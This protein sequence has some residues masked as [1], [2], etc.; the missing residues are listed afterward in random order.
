MPRDGSDYGY[1]YV[2]TIPTQSDLRRD[3]IFD[4]LGPDPWLDPQWIN[5]PSAP[6][7]P[8]DIDTGDEFDLQPSPDSVAER[9]E[10][11]MQHEQAL[12][13]EDPVE[14]VQANQ[15][16]AREMELMAMLGENGGNGAGHEWID[17]TDDPEEIVGL[18]EDRF[19]ALLAASGGF[20][21][22]PEPRPAVNRRNSIG[23]ET[24]VSDASSVPAWAEELDEVI[25]NPDEEEDD[26]LVTSSDPPW[27]DWNNDDLDNQAPVPDIPPEMLQ[28]LPDWSTYDFSPPASTPVASFT[29]KSFLLPPPH[30][31]SIGARYHLSPTS[32]IPNTFLTSQCISHR[33]QQLN[34]TSLRPET[35][36][37]TL[38]SP[39]NSLFVDLVASL[40]CSNVDYDFAHEENTLLAKWEDLLRQTI[41]IHITAWDMRLPVSP[42]SSVS[43]LQRRIGKA[44][45]FLHYW[46]EVFHYLA[47]VVRNSRSSVKERVKLIP[48]DRDTSNL[49]ELGL[50][51]DMARWRVGRVESVLAGM[52]QGFFQAFAGERRKCRGWLRDRGVL[53]L[54]LPEREGVVRVGGVEV[55]TESG[56]FFSRAVT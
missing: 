44:S 16:E 34:L 49:P 1:G 38:L 21:A 19:D 43:Q 53:R 8:M 39:Y 13:L 50:S 28:N 3:T 6:G 17:N 2:T 18:E 22:G 24:V 4:D 47:G 26:F 55:R 5:S 7:S 36:W 30:E 32:T 51:G 9:L 20:E 45:L 12:N 52:N 40:T 23:A 35:R 31:G 25:S 56:G 15:V 10:E 42:C 37:S 14:W 46:E 41:Q 54:G 11:W 33:A 27:D 29:H 48:D